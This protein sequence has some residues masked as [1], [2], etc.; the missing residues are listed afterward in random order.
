M[1]NAIEIRCAACGNVALVDPSTGDV[2]TTRGVTSGPRIR[3]G[4]K[5]EQNA[6]GAGGIADEA[7][8]TTPKTTKT[9]ERFWI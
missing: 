2:L 3:E 9:G 6:D 8:G 4:V 7:E 1:D 5:E